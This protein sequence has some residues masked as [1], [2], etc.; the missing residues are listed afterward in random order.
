VEYA[1]ERVA[2]DS[3]ADKRRC[4]A[5]DQRDHADSSRSHEGSTCQ[6]DST[7]HQSSTCQE[8]STCHQSSTCQESN[9]RKRW[10]GQVVWGEDNQGPG[11][12][13]EEEEGK[14]GQEEQE[15]QEV[16]FTIKVKPT[17]RA[18]R[19]QFDCL[20]ITSDGPSGT[21]Q[22]EPAAPAPSLAD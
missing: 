20:E 22:A 11:W 14:E 16:W 13:E 6:E 3:V 12:E 2:F 21:A 5:E 7:C 18:C 19:A 10:K 4:Q 15:E 8:D 9:V 17:L 1:A